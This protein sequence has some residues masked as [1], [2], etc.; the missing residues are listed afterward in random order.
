MLKNKSLIYKTL[1]CTGFF[2]IILISTLFYKN[3]L[4]KEGIYNN[5][6]N[7]DG[8]K[9]YEVQ[10]PVN[11]TASI[12]PTWIPKNKNEVI[13]LNKEIAKVGNVEILLE[14]IMHRGNDIYFNFDANQFINYDS[15]EFLYN[16]IL[17]EDG[18]ATSYNLSNSFNIY[19]NNKTLIDVG[20]R[21]LGP[22]SKIYFGINIEIMVLLQMALPL[23][24][25]V[26]YY[27]GIH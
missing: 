7:Y 20:Q 12:E 17:N 16:Y 14:N 3:N 6:L 1:L 13:E 2:V 4:S 5:V 26:Q 22:N 27:M 25:M 24:I 11:F 15:G 21:G 8:Y 19:D 23:Y 10:K 9:I 18:T